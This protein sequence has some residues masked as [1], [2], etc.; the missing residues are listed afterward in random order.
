MGGDEVS[1]QREGAKTTNC[2]ENL[3]KK[4]T[5]QLNQE[6]RLALQQLVSRG[7]APARKLQHAHILLKSDRSEQG[8]KWSDQRIHEAFDVGLATIWRVRQRFLAEGLD[9][10]LNRRPQPERPQKRRLDGEQEAHL[11]ALACGATAEGEGQWTLRLLAQRM[12]KLGYVEQVSADTV[13][14]TLK[15]INSSLG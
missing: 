5:I 6:Q 3:V 7:T 11:I 12:V 1:L 8:P 15:K 14:R 9:G 4:Y 13:R 2:K 10:A